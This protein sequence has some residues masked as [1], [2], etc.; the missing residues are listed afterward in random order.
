MRSSPSNARCVLFLHCDRLGDFA[1]QLRCLH[2]VPIQCLRDAG[3][4][5]VLAKLLRRDVDGHAHAHPHV[6]P[7]LH[8]PAGLV[9]DPVAQALYQT[10]A[11]GDRDEDFR[12]DHSPLR[13]VPAQ[14]RFHATDLA[15]LS[16]DL[17]LVV[18]RQLAEIY[19]VPQVVQQVQL[20]EGPAF[21]VRVEQGTSAAARALGRIHR[22]LGMDHEL[23]SLA[24]IRKD[25]NAHR[26]RKFD[27]PVEN[28]EW[29]LQCLDESACQRHAVGHAGH[30]FHQH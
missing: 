12:A 25:R 19:G 20:L 15:A 18:Q 7:G 4:Q 8:L 26:A 6:S 17:G 13:M 9:T 5:V 28:I 21:H 3:D 30:V 2:V 24:V 11:F 22:G 10:V 16:I 27:L 14:Q 23:A 29:T 1:Q